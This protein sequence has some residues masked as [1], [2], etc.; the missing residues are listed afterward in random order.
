MD[1]WRS[2]W[3]IAVDV[4]VVIAVARRHLPPPLPCA[5]TTDKVEYVNGMVAEP[6]RRTSSLDC[7]TDPSPPPP[8]PLSSSQATAAAAGATAC[9]VASSLTDAGQS[10]QQHHHWCLHFTAETIVFTNFI[11]KDICM[12]SAYSH[13]HFVI[14]RWSSIVC[15]WRVT[16]S[17]ARRPLWVKPTRPTQPSALS[18]TGNE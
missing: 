17:W 12:R 10:P 7:L 16:T 3:E 4:V 9:C 13:F 1:C 14:R 15:R 6:L 8:P 2:T 18:G 11:S 5:S